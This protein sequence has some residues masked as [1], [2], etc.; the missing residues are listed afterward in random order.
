MFCTASETEGESCTHRKTYSNPK[1]FITVRNNAI[2]MLCFFVACFGDVSLYFMFISFLV[3]FGLL[4]DQ[5]LGKSSSL[6]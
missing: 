2:V 4:S 6:G 5:V 3:L 1:L